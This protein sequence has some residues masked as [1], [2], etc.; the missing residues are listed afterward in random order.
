MD[1]YF[2]TFQPRKK[3][4][5]GKFHIE[6]SLSRESEATAKQKCIL[7]NN[8]NDKNFRKSYSKGE[9]TFF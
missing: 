6:A 5:I 4:I 2:V 1:V 3:N 9:F 7:K 8:C